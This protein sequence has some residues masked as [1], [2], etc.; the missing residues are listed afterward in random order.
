VADLS[1]FDLH[2]ALADL[3]CY[4]RLAAA[5]GLRTRSLEGRHGQTGASDPY[6]AVDRMA[7]RGEAAH[8]R[9]VWARLVRVNGVDRRVLLWLAD[10]GG[11]RPDPA[12]MAVLFAREHGP[13]ELREAWEKAE[14]R[15][16]A[17]VEAYGARGPQRGR[18]L[19]TAGAILRDRMTR[20]L[21]AEQAAES[22]LR[23][24]GME[25]VARA[26]ATWLS[27]VEEKC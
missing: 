17:A 5:G 11:S 2:R 24:W 13:L 23:A 12:T 15:Q 16:K 1:V 8:A 6:V 22:A 4:G 14:Q 19:T 27:I 26:I 10:R 21:R 25:R 20:S 9:R 18:T 3:E 7:D